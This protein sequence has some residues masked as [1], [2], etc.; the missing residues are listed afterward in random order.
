MCIPWTCRILQEIHKK[1]CKNSKTLDMVNLSTSKIWVDANPS[2][3]C[4]NPQ[5]ISHPS[6]YLTLSNSEEMLHSLYRCIWWYLWSKI[7]P[8]TWW[9]RISYS[10]SFTHIHWHSMEMEHYRTRSLWCILY[11]HKMEWLPSRSLNNSMQ[12]PQTTGKI[13]KWKKCK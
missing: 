4:L 1:L 13:P 7:F 8:G 3:H 2:Q 9:N 12:W 10:I 11:S 6:T 5:G